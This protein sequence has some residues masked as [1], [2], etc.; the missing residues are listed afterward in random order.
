LYVA[1][2]LELNLRTGCL[3]VIKYLD[4]QENPEVYVW[5]RKIT[6]SQNPEF[7][8]DHWSA[9]EVNISVEGT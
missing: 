4:W 5:G 1:K 8:E 2:W 9:M 6:V 3:W 7:L